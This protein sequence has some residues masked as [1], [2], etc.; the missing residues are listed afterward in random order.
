MPPFQPDDVVAEDDA[1]PADPNEAAEEGFVMP[2]ARPE[3]PY[4][5]GVPPHQTGFAGLPKLVPFG[6]ELLQE[7]VSQ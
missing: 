1:P 3:K 7:R 6:Q 4:E 2:K 5:Q